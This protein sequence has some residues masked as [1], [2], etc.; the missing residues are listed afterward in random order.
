M[1]VYRFCLIRLGSDVRKHITPRK[2]ENEVLKQVG[3]M[4][5]GDLTIHTLTPSDTRR[6]PEGQTPEECPQAV[7]VVF[8]ASLPDNK[9]VGK[10]TSPSCRTCRCTNDVVRDFTCRQ[11]SSNSLRRI[12][13]QDLGACEITEGILARSLPV[14]F[15]VFS[16]SAIDQF[17]VHA[18]LV[19]RDLAPL[20][21]YRH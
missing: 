14:T 8:G 19:V 20:P 10:W 13:E 15:S 1:V 16:L 11:T 5:P 3:Q 4:R 17:Y 6:C 7:F 2:F 18:R 21:P 12:D 9:Q